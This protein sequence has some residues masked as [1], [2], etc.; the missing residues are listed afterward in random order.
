MVVALVAGACMLGGSGLVGSADLDVPGQE[1]EV[2]H[3][4]HAFA[5]PVEP[6]AVVEP[7][8]VVAPPPVEPVVVTTVP[9]PVVWEPTIEEWFRP[10]GRNG[11]TEGLVGA[12]AR[13]A[14]R[15]NP[16][17]YLSDTWGRVA[18]S[19]TSDHHVSQS[20]SWAGDL[21]VRGI[22][23]PT[24]ATETAARRIGAALGE[25]DWTGGD[26]TR[27]IDG[28]RFQVLWKVAGHYN[29]VH[30]GVRKVG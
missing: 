20:S 30:V 2:H 28:Y 22:Q 24:P 7:L 18:G 16:P 9:A 23:Q 1:R 8:P 21:A 13:L 5:Q 10:S 17:L 4:V 11:G 6:V 25:P 29:H 12:L 14:L 26:L 3:A 19:A 27:T 15:D